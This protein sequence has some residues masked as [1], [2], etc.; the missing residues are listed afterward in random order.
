MSDALKKQAAIAALNEIGDDAI[1]GIGSGSTIN[2]FIEQ[3]ATIKG[4]IQACVA[5]S[6]QSAQ[7]IRALGIPVI[8]LNSAPSL[9]LYIDSADEITLLGTM[10]KGGGG[11]LTREKI[12]ASVAE[13]FIC[14][15]DNSKLVQRLGA[16]P[17]AIEVIPIARSYVAREI[18]KLGG[19]PVYRQGFLT[20]NGNIILDIYHLE[21]P[22]PLA[23]EN[24][25]NLI[26]GVVENGIFAN[27]IANKIILAEESTG[28]QVLKTS[29]VP[30]ISPSPSSDWS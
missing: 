7:R 4:R 20:D 3:L 29:V 25:L 8:D 5:S 13:Q 17:L 27:R 22:V 26:C 21:M 28:V 19:D 11:A 18:V 1:L 2:I 6:E 9:P 30:D 14:I 16:F 23:L 24:R 12:I 10:I 15:V